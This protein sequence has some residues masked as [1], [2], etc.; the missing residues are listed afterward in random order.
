MTVPRNRGGGSLD[1]AAVAYAR[2]LANPCAARMTHPLYLGGQ[3]GYLFRAESD[4]IIANGATELGCLGFW[5]PGNMI[6]GN[7]TALIT[8][9]A[10]ATNTLGT[11]L[12]APGRTFLTANAAAARCVSACIQISF[13]GTEFNRSGFVALGQSTYSR[14]SNG[15]YNTAVMRTLAE[16][17]RRMPDGDVEVRLVPNLTSETYVNPNGGDL[18]DGM[19]GLFFSVFGVPPSTGIRI[20]MVAV[21]EWL[22]KESVGMTLPNAATVADSKHTMNDV[23]RSMRSWGDWMYEGFEETAHAVS[24]LVGAARAGQALVRGTARAGALLLA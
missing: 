12:V 11:A 19:P 1:A 8:N 15:T 22:P 10:V 23:L 2:L 21:Y 3:G 4:Q 20:R 9:E 13:P 16:K 5:S 18:S 24:S 14:L 6:T 7:N 17:V